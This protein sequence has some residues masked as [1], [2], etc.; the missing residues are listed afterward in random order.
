MLLL[1]SL[2]APAGAQKKQCSARA[3]G[4]TQKERITVAR[5]EIMLGMET[6]RPLEEEALIDKMFLCLRVFFI[7]P[8]VSTPGFFIGKRAEK[9]LFSLN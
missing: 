6:T 2:S 5:Q 8:G 4:L 9:S 1:F 7:F 3:S